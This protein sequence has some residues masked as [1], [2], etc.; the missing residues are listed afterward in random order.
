[1]KRGKRNKN[2]EVKIIFSQRVLYSLIAIFV[3]A[4][5]GVGVFASTYKNTAGVG[6]DASEV[7]PGTF[8]AGGSYVFPSALNVNGVL[9]A[10]GLTTTGIL[11]AG[12]ADIT[13]GITAGSATITSQIKAGG[14]IA[15]GI[16][17]DAIA[18]AGRATVIDGNGITSSG[19]ITATDVKVTSQIKAGG[20]IA[21]GINADLIAVGAINAGSVNANLYLLNGAP[22]FTGSWREQIGTTRDGTP[23]SCNLR[24][25]GGLLLGLIDCG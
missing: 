13:N 17:A 5:V 24:F 1:M 4:I 2:I 10:G 11:N 12:S 23:Y 19:L 9:T 6:H 16:N 3:F 7:G 14:V 15:N 21:N 18:V 8:A 22:G 25:Q 20:V